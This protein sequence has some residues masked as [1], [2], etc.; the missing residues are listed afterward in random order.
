MANVPNIKL[1][2][3]VEMPQ[4]GF[5]VYQVPDFDQCKQAVLDALKAGYR[6]IDTA[7]AYGNEEAVG[8]AI[9]ESGVD[10]HDIFI[11]TKVWLNA[12][13]DGTAEASIQESMKK[14]GTDYLD[15]VL[16]HQPFGDYYGA[17]R[18]LEKMYKAG[19]LRAIGVSNFYPRVYVDLALH[20]DVK[21]LVNQVE[22][23]VFDQE[24]GLRPWLKKYGAAI[25]SWGP[26]AEGQNG[27]FTDPTLTKIGQ[28]YGKTPAQV[29]LRFLAQDGVII[30]PKSVHADRMAENLDIWDFQLSDD[31]MATIKK[32]D[33]AKSIFIDHTTPEAAEQFYSWTNGF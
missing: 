3:G 22:T 8:A 33:T 5:G 32:M 20:A 25:E 26:L 23:H 15:L 7:Q 9:K 17:Y 31:E 16:L 4:E 14:L 30:I 28:N 2:N 24:R 27:L 11:T 19:T 18:D 12:F 13:G 6:H 21:P 1:A 10:R 29:A